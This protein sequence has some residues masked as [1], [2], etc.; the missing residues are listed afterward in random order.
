MVSLSSQNLL[1]ITVKVAMTRNLLTIVAVLSAGWFSPPLLAEY[2]GNSLVSSDVVRQ[3]G[4]ERSWFT[5]AEVA[6]ARGRIVHL[7]YFVSSTDTYTVYEVTYRERNRVFSERDIDRF[8]E[9]L[10]VEGAEKAAKKFIED[11]KLEE[12]EGTLEEKTIPRTF[13]YV[14]T[15]RGI[16]QA[17]D[18]ETGRS[19]WATVVGNR[20]YPTESPAA[21][22]DYLAIINGS[23]LYLL[24]RRTGEVGW[25]RRIRGVSGAGP[26]ITDTYVTVPTIG[27]D[28]ELYEIDE[29]RTTPHSYKSNGR[30]LVQPTVTPLSIA[31]P[32][33]RGFLYVARANKHG[34]RY[35]LEAGNTIVAPAV[36]AP[37]NRFF[38][39][40]I[41]GYVYNVHENSGSEEWRFSTGE[42]MSNAPM[43]FGDS[44]YAVTD[45]GNLFSIDFET[46]A[47]NWASPYIRQII[48]A[49]A[50]RLYCLGITGKLVILEAATGGR[51]GVVDTGLQDIYFANMLSDRI[52]L[53]TQT[54]LIQCVRET[55][56]RW[57]LLH[58]A[59]AEEEQNKPPEIEMEGIQK[60]EPKPVQPAGD[61]NDPFGGNLFGGGNNNQ[62][63]PPAAGGGN[64]K[65]DPFGGGNPFGGAGGNNGGGGNNNDPFGLG[66][67][68]PFK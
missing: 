20:N 64:A 41:D 18:G 12:I 55:Q 19:E 66:D 53:A 54:G 11:L 34:V 3:F 68:D 52:Y 37:P 31:W 1:R 25:S 14:V 46:G 60:P 50:D 45:K 36:Y 27:G 35:R 5:Q 40:S 57:P 29:T 58:A 4:L 24:K 62:N 43:V 22:E 30:L 65:P 26:A 49:S 28:L 67:D 17:I 2:R 63:P 32:T 51:I 61:P 23:D 42:A 7:R 6:P 33:D 38:A 21:S 48:S 59:A 13:L 16:V 39:T 44:V 8:G 47:Q 56:L 15:D 9:K 10:G